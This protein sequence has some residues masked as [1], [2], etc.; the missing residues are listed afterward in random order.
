M[1]GGVALAA[2]RRDR[3]RAGAGPVEGVARLR[4][5]LL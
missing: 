3:V 1:R 5:Y 4:A 2:S